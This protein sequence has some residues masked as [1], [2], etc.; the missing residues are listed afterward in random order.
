MQYIQ[1]YNI[2]GLSEKVFCLVVATA[3]K[4]KLRDRQSDSQ[5]LWFSGILTVTVFVKIGI[6][7]FI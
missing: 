4:T 2:N 1:Q 7:I 3:I 6:E 5:L